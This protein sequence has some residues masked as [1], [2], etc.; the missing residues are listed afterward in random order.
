MLWPGRK[1]L[2]GRMLWPGHKILTARMLWPGRKIL[3]VR[4]W[5]PGHN[6]RGSQK[7]AQRSTIPA[8][9]EGKKKDMYSLPQQAGK[10]KEGTTIHY[11]SK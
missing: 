3:T 10:P 1:I 7:K 6:K 5:W 4:I 2:T 11:F 8:N 9:E